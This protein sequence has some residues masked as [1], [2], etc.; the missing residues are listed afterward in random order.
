MKKKVVVSIICIAVLLV[1]FTIWSKGRNVRIL[2]DLDITILSK[3]VMHHPGD[4]ITTVT[5]QEDIERFVKI[6]QSMHL[7]KTFP[8]GRDGIPFI[9]DLYYKNGNKSDY[10]IA[11]DYIIADDGSY[12]KTDRDYCDDFYKLYDELSK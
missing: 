8:N 2:E 10:G 5:K 3:V 6:L 1:L 4:N 7:N 9:I 11:S 12:Y